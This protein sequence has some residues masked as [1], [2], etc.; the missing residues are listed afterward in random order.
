MFKNIN[1]WIKNNEGYFRLT[2][3][4]SLLL[5]SWAIIYGFSIANQLTWLSSLETRSLE[6]EKS[7]YEDSHISCIY[8]YKNE[9]INEDC[10]KQLDIEALRKNIVYSETVIDLFIDVDEYD[11]EYS[12]D[13]FKEGYDLWAIE[14]FSSSYF[15]TN[16]YPEM[17][18]RRITYVNK[19]ALLFDIN[20]RK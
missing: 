19:K 6:L 15:N 3:I 18:N 8:T 20:L 14:L 12:D 10:K 17:N 1:K 4:F 2:E 5:A 13:T 9:K 11:L 16:I 7:S